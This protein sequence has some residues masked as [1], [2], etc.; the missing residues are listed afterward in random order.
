MRGGQP[1]A[2]PVLCVLSWTSWSSCGS[3]VCKARRQIHGSRTGCSSD[4]CQVPV[5]GACRAWDS[6][7]GAPMEGDAQQWSL[8]PGQPVASP[9]AWATLPGL[10]AGKAVGIT[11]A[12]G[13]HSALLPFPV[14]LTRDNHPAPHSPF[15]LRL[16]RA[17]LQVPLSTKGFWGAM[18]SWATW[19]RSRCQVPPPAQPGASGCGI[20]KARDHTE[21]G[22]RRW[23]ELSPRSPLIPRPSRLAFC[24]TADQG[25]WHWA[26][27][28]LTQHMFLPGHPSPCCSGVGPREG[29]RS[30][31]DS[32]EP[33]GVGN[34][35]SPMVVEDM[36]GD[37]ACDSSLDSV[38]PQP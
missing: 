38:R 29:R 34:L 10:V 33:M 30:L 28:A 21:P 17:R 23:A 20:T 2:A 19:A 3:L 12:C 36:D 14:L 4:I 16:P 9:V 15:L 25:T 5:L 37:T 6:G 32:K 18:E 7:A 11:Q 26:P 22:Q 27:P 13:E 35:L 8:D 24:S 1:Q 31:L